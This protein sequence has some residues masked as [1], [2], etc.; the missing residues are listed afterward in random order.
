MLFS[1][2]LG[3][4]LRPAQKPGASRNIKNYEI[5]KCFP[6]GFI[7]EQMLMSRN[8]KVTESKKHR[9]SRD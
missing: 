2:F 7:P 9:T 3:T 6:D 1:S 8:R 5:S 4:D